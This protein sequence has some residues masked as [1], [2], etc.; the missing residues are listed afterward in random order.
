MALLDRLARR[1]APEL[2]DPVLWARI[3]DYAFDEDRPERGFLDRLRELTRWRQETA[4]AALEEYRRFV[5]LA[6]VAPHPVTPPVAVD[7]VW[8]LHLTDTRDYWQR[9]CGVTLGRE[10]HHTPS[11]GGERE[12]ARWKAQYADTLT[13]YARV[14]GEAPPA[15]FWPHPEARFADAAEP[16]LYSPRR[17]VPVRKGTLLAPL[18]MAAGCLAVLFGGGIWQLAGGVLMALSTVWLLSALI[19]A[20]GAGGSGSVEVAVGSDAGGGSDGD[21]GDGGCGGD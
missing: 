15:E 18:L 17:Q 21:G 19:G 9:F 14:F 1:P 10:L 8:H 3:R 16:R 2:P 7:L 11:R 12:R 5:Y 4:E 6:M 20:A 13:T